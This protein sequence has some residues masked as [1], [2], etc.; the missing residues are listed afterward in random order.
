MVDVF[1]IDIYAVGVMALKL[2]GLKQSEIERIKENES[3]ISESLLEAYPDSIDFIKKTLI[4]DPSVRIN[5][6]KLIKLLATKNKNVPNEDFYISK[7]FEHK[8]SKLNEVDLEK[9]VDLYSEINLYESAK[10]YAY[11]GLNMAEN[12]KGNRKKIAVWLSKCGKINF[13][14]GNFEKSIEKFSKALKILHD[15]EEREDMDF[16]QELISMKKEAVSSKNR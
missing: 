13:M 1:K 8:I 15:S 4:K 3:N 14:M 11:L 12:Q 10:K 16:C 7:Y 5:H 9:Y 6:K 2:M